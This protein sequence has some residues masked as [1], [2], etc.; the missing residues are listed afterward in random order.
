M[1]DDTHS[2]RINTAP[3]VRMPSIMVRRLSVVAPIFQVI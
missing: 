2:D 1:A 3:A